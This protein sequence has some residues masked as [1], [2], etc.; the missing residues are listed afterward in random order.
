[1]AR[2]AEAEGLD[3][4]FSYDHLFRVR[5]PDRPALSSG[6]LLA[7]VA[8]T[9]STVRVGPLVS[10]VSLLPPPVLVD[11]LVT[12]D[13]LATGRLIAGLGIGDR[14]TG[15]ENATYG[16]PLPALAERLRQVETVAAALRQ[17]GIPVWVGGRSDVA[18]RLAGRVADGWN[19]WDG[20]DAELATFP[21][22]SRR[23]V[24][25]TWSG[26]PPNED[27]LAAHLDRMA[28]RGVAWVVYGPPPQIDWTSFMT[29]LAGAAEVVH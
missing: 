6:P 8:S 4:V 1:V 2:R 19:C 9:T 21:L 20:S 17:Q 15:P 24:E 7:A 11:T 28:N 10:R 29:K 23:R 18:R 25:V 22:S 26:P 5:R 27:G 3:G 16:M 14:Q 13:R 12:I